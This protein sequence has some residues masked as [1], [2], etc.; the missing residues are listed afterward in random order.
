MYQDQKCI[1]NFD[2][3]FRRQESL[4]E[5]Y[6]YI[7][8]FIYFTYLLTLFNDAVSVPTLKFSIGLECLCKRPFCNRRYHS[9]HVLA[10]IE[11]GG[12][13]NDVVSNCSLL[14]RQAA[15][16]MGLKCFRSEILTG[17]L[18]NKTYEC[19]IR[20]RWKGNIREILV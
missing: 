4:P 6:L 12:L 13:F 15:K 18:S 8:L 9:W 10:E 7:C 2:T 19:D 5:T 16:N 14:L 1:Q 17:A 11:F 3:E 20:F